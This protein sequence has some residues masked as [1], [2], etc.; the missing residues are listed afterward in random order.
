MQ[1]T[2]KK[3]SEKKTRDSGNN[4]ISGMNYDEAY[5]YLADKNLDMCD[6]TIEQFINTMK[7]LT[8]EHQEFIITLII[9]HYIRCDNEITGNK[10]DHL[11]KNISK[12][13][14]KSPTAKNSGKKC[15]YL[16]Y[17]MKMMWRN[18]SQTEINIEKLPM[19]L[20]KIIFNYIKIICDE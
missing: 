16:F 12:N 5:S 17:D 7:S 10:Y 3:N 15:I 4:P 9:Y 14:A 1:S 13:F 2:S 8:P 18:S 11:L 19:D 20:Q 6:N